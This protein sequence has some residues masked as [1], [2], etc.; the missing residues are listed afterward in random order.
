MENNIAFI[1]LHGGSLLNLNLINSIIPVAE[2]AGQKSKLWMAITNSQSVQITN[3]EY[4][5]IKKYYQ[6]NKGLY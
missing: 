4:N 5:T 3:D 6:S 1:E 2:T